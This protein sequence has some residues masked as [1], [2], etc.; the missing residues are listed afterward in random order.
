MKLGMVLKI[1][2]VFHLLNNL[3]PRYKFIGIKKIKSEKNSVK[4]TEIQY[5]KFRIAVEM[6]R[7]VV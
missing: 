1:L 7:G 2:F 5:Y 6:N 3:N 4:K